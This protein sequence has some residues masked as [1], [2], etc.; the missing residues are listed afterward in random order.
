MP[1]CACSSF[2][3]PTQISS[4]LHFWILMNFAV[5]NLRGRAT[6]KLPHPWAFLVSISYFVES[7]AQ[8]EYSTRCRRV[9]YKQR[10]ERIRSLFVV[11]TCVCLKFFSEIQQCNLH[12]G[13]YIVIFARNFVLLTKSDR[14]SSSDSDYI[15]ECSVSISTCL[16]YIACA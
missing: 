14:S 2:I 13:F 10:P 4:R 3:L 6:D 15:S 11:S 1:S 9:G 5:A 16:A 12:V 7:V 8:K